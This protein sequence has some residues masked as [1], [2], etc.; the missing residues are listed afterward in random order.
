MILMID[1]NEDVR[2]QNIKEAFAKVS[3]WEIITEDRENE[4]EGTYHKG[5]KPIDGIFASNTIKMKKG[6]TSHLVSFHLII[7]EYGLTLNL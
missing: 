2:T 5:S 3:M 1:L 7:E 6:D 4:A